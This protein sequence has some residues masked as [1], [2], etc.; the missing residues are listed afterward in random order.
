MTTP[1]ENK[2]PAPQGKFAGMPYDW[3]RPTLAK[4][5]ARWW[6]PDEPRF[7]TPKTFGWGFDF[8]LYRLFH[9]KKS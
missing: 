7:F 1:D 3:R 9:W 2:I 6:N 4:L 5:K 8:N